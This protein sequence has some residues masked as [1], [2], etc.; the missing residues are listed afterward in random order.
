MY[1]LIAL[2]VVLPACY[3]VFQ[4]PLFV[5]FLENKAYDF[6]FLMRGAV[7]PGS[8]VVVIAI[9]EQSLD[10]LGRWPWPRIT[11]AKLLHA[12]AAQQPA[13]MGVDIMFSESEVSQSER[14][15]QDIE[16][17]L[18]E[19]GVLDADLSNKINDLKNAASPDR[20][21]GQVLADYG[22]AVLAVA[23]PMGGEIKPMHDALYDFTFTTLE[24]E[25]PFQLPM[26]ARDSLVPVDDI[27]DGVASL[28]S[29]NSSYDQDG[30]IRREPLY[31]K[32]DDGYYVPSFGLEIARHYLGISRAD[33]YLSAGSAVEL[34]G[35]GLM[36]TDIT[37]RMIINFAGPTATFRTVSAFDVIQGKVTDLHG[38]VLML[39]L[40]ALGTTDIHV[41]PFSRIPGVEKQAAVVENILHDKFM[42][43]D[44]FTKA[45]S[46]IF[47]VCAAI[48]LVLLLPRSQAWV[49]ASSVLVLLAVYTVG[50]QYLFEQ[51]RFWI[52]L[53]V[54]AIAVFLLYTAMIGYRFFT[55]EKKSR[56][57]RQMFSSYTTKKVVDQLLA[58]PELALLGG[59]NRE[60]TVMFSDVRGFTTYCESRTP[61]QVVSLLN[62]FLAEM[63]D[64]I[65]DWDGT[66]DKFVGDEIMAFWGAPA[67]QKDHAILAFCCTLAMMN[68]IT[69]MKT[70]WVERGLEPMDIGVGLN[71]GDVVVGNIGS[72][73]KKMDY[74]IIGDTVN[75]GARVEAITRNYNDY[76]I[77]TEFTLERIQPYLIKDDEGT[78][79]ISME[80]GSFDKIHVNPLEHVKVKG[81]DKPVMIY[82]IA[83]THW[84]TPAPKK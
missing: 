37:G 22:H 50:T 54:P 10:K 45:F 32:I 74:T 73:G 27:L 38:K 61:E 47:I 46:A 56:Q 6:R 43:L 17:M 7:D 84:G 25:E 67:E 72:Q 29:V 55:E 31:V 77:I 13:V 52:Y 53:M 39:G 34:I 66:L 24:K 51:Y 40:T 16:S 33:M 11:Q 41:T 2:L 9:D 71:S 60:V 81:K 64:V 69:E 18:Q 57:I 80:Q 79:S 26:L 63:T 78:Y 20:Y 59:S 48:F 76:L 65:F 42:V 23:L 36:E 30:A 83:L 75:L 4:P 21:L 49:S 58:N 70:A 15:L 35:H 62:D 28:G 68:R 1:W 14:S 82:E 8:E 5:Q 12:M 44:E 3:T 19:K